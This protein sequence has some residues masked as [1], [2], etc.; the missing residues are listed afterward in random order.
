[1]TIETDQVRVKCAKIKI[2]LQYIKKLPP[3]SETMFSWSEWDVCIAPLKHLSVCQL[4]TDLFGAHGVGRQ[5]FWGYDGGHEA[6]R[7][8]LAQH[9]GLHSLLGVKCRWMMR[10]GVETSLGYDNETRNSPNNWCKNDFSLKNIFFKMLKV[11]LMPS[12][13]TCEI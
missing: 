4:S 6:D 5:F 13:S 1:M 7:D 10:K 12:R 8:S 2:Y 3:S 9:G 11:P